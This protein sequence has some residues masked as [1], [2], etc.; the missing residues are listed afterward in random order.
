MMTIKQDRRRLVN[1]ETLGLAEQILKDVPVDSH[2][3]DP[4]GGDSGCDSSDVG[5]KRKRGLGGGFS[6]G[7]STGPQQ[8]VGPNRSGNEKL[9][10]NV[11]GKHFM[12]LRSTLERIPHTRISD[13][14]ELDPAYDFQNDEY[15]FDRNPKYFSAILDFFR[16]G[17]LHFAHCLCGPSIKKE[18]DFWGI[19]DSYI[20]NCCWRAYKS[21]EEEE[22]TLEILDKALYDGPPKPSKYHY[23]NKTD[24]SHTN[25]CEGRKKLWDFLDVPTSS[26]FA[27]VRVIVAE[28]LRAKY[29]N[30]SLCD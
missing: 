5:G 7:V 3:D 21:Y 6:E 12:T 11:G 4:S 8:R 1:R 28:I 20:S 27:T 23:C 22:E 10:F 25:Y 13:L 15:F 30:V 19:R 18:L 17:E 14:D 24:G 29:K 16:T 26:I 9:I 2:N